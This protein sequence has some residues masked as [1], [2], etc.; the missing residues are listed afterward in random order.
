LATAEA[1]EAEAEAVSVLAR[2]LFPMLPEET[3]FRFL[4][5]IIAAAE[6]TVSIITA[7]Y[8]SYFRT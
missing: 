4:A 3:F 6:N 2:E 8:Y 7:I 5:A 1:A